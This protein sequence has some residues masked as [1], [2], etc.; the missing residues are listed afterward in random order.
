[1]WRKITLVAALFG[2]SIA[3][4]IAYVS[5]E[6]KRHLITVCNETT[7][8]KISVE[9]F[10]G[11]DLIERTEIV[12]GECER[13]KS[14]KRYEGVFRINLQAGSRYYEFNSDYTTNGTS[15]ELTLTD[16]FL[17]MVCERDDSDCSLHEV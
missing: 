16:E 5:H 17:I 2:T 9:I 3:L 11:D 7:L 1:M 6:L 12:S 10:L 15:N 4:P 14:Y 8:P 13:A